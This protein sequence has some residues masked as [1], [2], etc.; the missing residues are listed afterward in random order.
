MATTTLR[1]YQEKIAEL[2]TNGNT[3]EVIRHCTHILT[4]FPKNAIIY[5]Y[6]G[7]ALLNSRRWEE[8]IQVFRRVLTAYPDDYASHHNLAIIYNN[9]NQTDSAIW[10]YE[11]AYESNGTDPT[12]VKSLLGLYQS[13]KK[14]E[15]SRLPITAGTAARQFKRNGLH[16]Q[17]IDT[18]L[19]VLKRSPRRVD[20][21]LLLS[22]TYWEANRPVDAARTAIEVLKAL[23]F[24]YDANKILAQLWLSQG[25]PSDASRYLSNMEQIAPYDA[26]ELIQNAPAPD[27]AVTLEEFNYQG[28]VQKEVGSITPDWVD[29]FDESDAKDISI[30]KP[31]FDKSDITNLKR[32]PAKTVSLVEAVNTE[33]TYVMG[34]IQPLGDFDDIPSEPAS[35]P[36][37]LPLNEEDDDPMSWLKEQGVEITSSDTNRYADLLSDENAEIAYPQNQ[38]PDAWLD[39]DLLKT[40]NDPLDILSSE[41][42]TG[43]TGLLSKPRQPAQ[44]A[45]VNL[46]FSQDE[47]DPM[48]WMNTTNTGVTGL[49]GNQ[50]TDE[51]ASLDD[52]DY[53]DLSATQA[54]RFAE[55][56]DPMAWLSTSGTGVTSLLGNQP[57]PLFATPD[58]SDAFD[59]DSIRNDVMATYDDSIHTDELYTTEEDPM[60]WLNTSGTGVTGL[61]GQ[62]QAYEPV[63]EAPHDYKE[64]PIADEFEDAFSDLSAT[65]AKRFEDA[66]DPLGWLQGTRALEG[67]ET[68]RFSFSPDTNP[69]RMDLGAFDFDEVGY[70]S[71]RPAE[72]TE[73]QTNRFVEMDDPLA[74]LSGDTNMAD[75]F[76]FGSPS[77]NEEAPSSVRAT[78]WLQRA[79]T[80]EPTDSMDWLIAEP[81]LSHNSTS[82]NPLDLPEWVRNRDKARST[83]EVADS[84]GIV[85]ADEVSDDANE[86]LASAIEKTDPSAILLER[87]FSTEDELEQIWSDDSQINR[88][89]ELDQVFGELG[90]LPPQ[91][92]F[93]DEEAEPTH[94]EDFTWLSE[95]QAE[96]VQKAEPSRL[97]DTGKLVWGQ[98]EDDS[99]N[100][101][102]DAALIVGGEIPE[103]LVHASMTDTDQLTNTNEMNTFIERD[104]RFGMVDEA[105]EMEEVITH[106][107]PL[108]DF[109]DT[110]PQYDEAD[111]T[112]LDETDTMLDWLNDY[113]QAEEGAVASE[114][115]SPYPN[116]FFGDANPDERWQNQPDQQV[117]DS[118]TFTD[119]LNQDALPEALDEEVS[120]TPS[121]VLNIANSVEA[122]PVLDW[123]EQSSSL[124]NMEL[125]D[126]LDIDEITQVFDS[127]PDIQ[128]T[129]TNQII[130]PPTSET[131]MNTGYFPSATQIQPM[132]NG[133]EFDASEYLP[134]LDES[135]MFEEH[136]L[137]PVASA[138]HHIDNLPI[139]G[140]LSLDPAT[141]HPDS[142]WL[143]FSFTPVAG[144]Q[145]A[146]PREFINEAENTLLSVPVEATNMDIAYHLEGADF[147]AQAAPM[148]LQQIPDWLTYDED[149]IALSEPIV[150]FGEPAPYIVVAPVPPPATSRV[151]THEEPTAFSFAMP[152][153]A[154]AVEEY[155]ESI[156]ESSSLGFATYQ[157]ADVV[158][159]PTI[160]DDAPFAFG[161]ATYQQPDPVEEDNQEALHSF[162]FATYQQPD[163]VEEDNQE[164]LHSFGLAP[165]EAD[166]TPTD[167]DLFGFL[168]EEEADHDQLVEDQEPND[169][170][171][172]WD[173]VAL[174]DLQPDA[175][176]SEDDLYSALDEVTTLYVDETPEL[177]PIADIPDWLDAMVPGLDFNINEADDAPIETAFLEVEQRAP[178]IT[179]PIEQ[180][181]QPTPYDFQWL[182]DI[183]EE[184]TVNIEQPKRRP[185]FIF[186]RPPLWLRRQQTPNAPSD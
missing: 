164:A 27:N 92:A 177:E 7:D 149:D 2:L 104:S 162:G 80:D 101:S 26:L 121:W 70:N 1:D 179:L 173:N 90:Y 8:A 37:T 99:F 119:W 84:F 186:S 28:M 182:V 146:P 159:E 64:E 175:L 52:D 56:D 148:P 151:V 55:L 106:P 111:Q 169:A 74:W 114:V 9:L 158:E 100:P 22:Q 140:L 141:T 59:F 89:S 112:P 153:Q 125:E 138:S 50:A 120:S 168:Y 183:V 180:P 43:I 127:L 167:D 40:S 54:K 86:W 85:D 58:E 73:T 51:P 81:E 150:P 69:S 171:M 21:L 91:Q 165:D 34:D 47:E 29:D 33:D 185:R 24:C 87:D 75:E 14:F 102:A 10:H 68:A 38:S 49:L 77:S 95:L 35:I 76:D 39:S 174:D 45:T 96:Q 32:S 97:L 5:R 107:S 46:G 181:A 60:A 19:K 63:A 133:V 12:L 144:T 72:L 42:G 53:A 135:Y 154:D 137:N 36:D 31:L 13:R 88:P 163:P 139:G 41:G 155:D 184:E 142:E 172:N 152:Q 118:T 161:F 65:Q 134:D 132:T 4:I 129:S 98:S 44:S 108:F 94:E 126:T 136:D 6:L 20:L 62:S 143:D 157:Q 71:G 113:D 131:R 18:I 93:D 166:T 124:P 11:R 115:E 3:E 178:I 176:L 105:E 25:R 66:T 147:S 103:W 82:N 78:G 57:D 145:Y 23:P 110:T 109:V 160:E 48:A 17:A 156:D 79:V 15:G 30:S 123:Q 83:S 117:V 128:E 170:H 61:L 116:D 67:S 130:I 122:N 16:N